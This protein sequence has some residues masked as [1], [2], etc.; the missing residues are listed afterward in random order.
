MY[1][2]V[3]IMICY[4]VSFLNSMA[5]GAKDFFHYFWS[6]L[7]RYYPFFFVA[8][9]DSIG[10][11]GDVLIVW[12]NF[13]I[14]MMMLSKQVH[15]YCHSDGIRYSMCSE[16]VKVLICVVWISKNWVLNFLIL[17]IEMEFNN[18]TILEEFVVV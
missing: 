5:Y 13:K 6:F 14:L 15:A 9:V 3:E 10:S 12:T 8:R 11:G 2:L 7:R 16:L 4:I 18:L 17:F 1:L